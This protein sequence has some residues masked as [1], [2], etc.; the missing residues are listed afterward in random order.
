MGESVAAL[1]MAGIVPGV[2]WS[3]LADGMVRLMADRLICQRNRTHIVHRTDHLI[4]HC[5]CL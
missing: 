2:F 5:G 3:V 4:E 1:F